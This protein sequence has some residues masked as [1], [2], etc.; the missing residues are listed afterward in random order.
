MAQ[1]AEVD[2][3]A[4]Q[5]LQPKPD[6]SPTQHGEAEPTT[7]FIVPVEQGL[8]T[9]IGPY[10]LLEKIG[11]GGFRIVY[12]AE[13]HEPVKRRVALKIIKLGLSKSFPAPLGPAFRPSECC[14]LPTQARFW[15]IG[16]SRS[17]AP[18]DSTRASA[19]L[20]L[21]LLDAGIR[22]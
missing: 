5:D 17:N 7:K 16:G 11:D 15:C 2:A 18:P 1:A 12:V 14:S 10:K 8:G 19:S 6:S 20:P 22:P 9:V 21:L 3:T 13:Q 4:S